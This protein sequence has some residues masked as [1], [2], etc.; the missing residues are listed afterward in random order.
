ML[1]RSVVVADLTG[2]FATIGGTLTDLYSSI[3]NLTGGSVG[4]QLFGDGAANIL[5]G[6]AGGDILQGRGGTDT[7]TG[8]S[9]ADAFNPAN[10]D[11]SDVIVDFSRAEGDKV[12]LIGG[13]TF[14]G[15]TGGGNI[16]NLSDGT[17]ITMTAGFV[18]TGADFI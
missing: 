10:G 18:W 16:A 4:D 2:L 3:E 13:I 9:G 12:D 7:L 15:T 1:F 14:T 6:G 11:D 8:G 5:V 17:T